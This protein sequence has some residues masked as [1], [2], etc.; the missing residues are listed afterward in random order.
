MVRK[1]VL[2]SALLVNM[3]SGLVFLTEPSLPG[4]LIARVVCGVSACR[5][6]M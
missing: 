4:L 6:L 1:R 5:P 2:V 3:V